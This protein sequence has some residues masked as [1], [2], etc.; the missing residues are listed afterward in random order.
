MQVCQEYRANLDVIDI[1]VVKYQLQMAHVHALENLHL[2]W[3][4]GQV[5]R[6]RLPLLSP[7]LPNEPMGECVVGTLPTMQLPRCQVTRESAIL[8]VQL[9]FLLGVQQLEP[10]LPLGHT[11]ADVHPNVPGHF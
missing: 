1:P 2:T 4:Q 9:N 11:V 3:G 5:Q 7:Q 10:A 6:L 8:T